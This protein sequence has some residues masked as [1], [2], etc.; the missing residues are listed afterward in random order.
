M[1]PGHFLPG[2]LLPRTVPTAD[3]CSPDISSQEQLLSKTGASRIDDPRIIVLK[4]SQ[5]KKNLLHILFQ[6]FISI[7]LVFNRLKN[8]IN[9]TINMQWGFNTHTSWHNATHKFS[10]QFQASWHYEIA[11]K[12]KKNWLKMKY[13]ETLH[14][15]CVTKI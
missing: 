15:K 14:K 7:I 6:T 4:K 2:H 3:R 8:M 9:K 12:S 11:L 10:M 1:L 5:T 13:L